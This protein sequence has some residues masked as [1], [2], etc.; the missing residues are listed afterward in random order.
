MHFYCLSPR[1]EGLLGLASLAELLIL[2]LPFF[3]AQLPH[4]QYISQAQAGFYSP[5]PKQAARDTQGRIRYYLCSS[6]SSLFFCAVTGLRHLFF[7]PPFL[8]VFP[9][10]DNFAT[11][12]P[13]Q[14]RDS[15]PL[16]R[17]VADHKVILLCDER[18]KLV[19]HPERKE[20]R[21]QFYAVKRRGSALE[22]E[23]S[24]RT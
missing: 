23:L 5:L 10:G 18:L 11:H 15:K 3:R 1:G 20:D 2:S 19:C 24:N 7:L 22:G 13:F 16:T 8:L 14:R 4:H 17:L 6:S 9:D 21:G 12:T